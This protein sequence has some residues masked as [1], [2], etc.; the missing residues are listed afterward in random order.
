MKDYNTR[1]SQEIVQ[2]KRNKLLRS[3]ANRD[4]KREKWVFERGSEIVQSKFYLKA[5]VL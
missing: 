1:D 4:A 3:I 2:E 5:F